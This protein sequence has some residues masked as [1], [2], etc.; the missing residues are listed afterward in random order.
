MRSR[1]LG[2]SPLVASEI[3]LGTSAGWLHAPVRNGC[4]DTG[5]SAEVCAECDRVPR[6]ILY[7]MG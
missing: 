4:A 7:P 3:R 6:E 5:L 1:P 2:R